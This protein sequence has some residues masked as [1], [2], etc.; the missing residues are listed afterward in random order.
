MKR[1]FKL[2]GIT[3]SSLIGII[4]LLAAIFWGLVKYGNY[5]SKKEAIRYQKEVC[6][7]T[8]TVTES[9]NVVPADFKPGDINRLDFYIIRNGTII[10]NKTVKITRNMLAS[11]KPVEVPFISFLT[12]D[13]IAI[14]AG[15]RF[16]LLTGVSYYVR[17]NWGMFGPVSDCFCESDGFTKINGQAPTRPSIDLKKKD[18]IIDFKLPLKGSMN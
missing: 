5:S 10:K 18:G 6:D 15:K 16:Y 4:V 14:A 7:T 17:Q 13:T 9:F 3:L 8:K 1:V 12:T 11:Q 2:I